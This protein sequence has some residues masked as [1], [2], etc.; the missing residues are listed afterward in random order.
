MQSD[1]ASA[2]VG[3][4]SSALAGQGERLFALMQTAENH[5]I[6]ITTGASSIKVGSTSNDGV[7]TNES[8][9]AAETNEAPGQAP[10]ATGSSAQL[11]AIALEKCQELALAELWV[12]P[13]NVQSLCQWL[14]FCRKFD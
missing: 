13:S 4:L 1:S 8:P 10:E 12:C 3:S 11:G 5:S 7:E 6:D 9:E 14:Q 2:E